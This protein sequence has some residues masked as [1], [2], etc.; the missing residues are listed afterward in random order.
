M[1]LTQVFDVYQGEIL[2]NLQH[3][4]ETYLDQSF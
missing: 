4:L 3:K 1:P 2:L